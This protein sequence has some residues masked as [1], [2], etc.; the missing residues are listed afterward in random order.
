[1]P[2]MSEPPAVVG[3]CTLWTTNDQPPATA[4]GSDIAH[5]LVTM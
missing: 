5:L 1:M 4:G 2:L 3:G